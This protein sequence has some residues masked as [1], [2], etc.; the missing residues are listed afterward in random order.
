MSARVE[1]NLKKHSYHELELD[2][3][4]N[5][6]KNIVIRKVKKKKTH[7]CPEH[8]YYTGHNIIRKNNFFD[9]YK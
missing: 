8:T 6:I 7:L 4:L 5:Y 3:F 1:L 9:L 2:F